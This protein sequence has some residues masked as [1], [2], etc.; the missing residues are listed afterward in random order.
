MRGE[1]EDREWMALVVRTGGERRRGS[2]FKGRRGD[3]EEGG[4]GSRS[5]VALLL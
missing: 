4:D 3:G 5:S 2:E 1:E